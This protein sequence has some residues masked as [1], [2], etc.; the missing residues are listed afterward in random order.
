MGAKMK[1]ANMRCFD[2]GLL[3]KYDT[4]KKEH[5]NI[6]MQKTAIIALGPSIIR[7]F[8]KKT[9]DNI[10][11]VLQD[12]SID[13]VN[14]ALRSK[15]LFKKWFIELSL[16]VNKVL[17]SH[18]D[19]DQGSKRWAHATKITSLYLRDLLYR[20]SEKLTEK[21]YKHAEEM[22]YVPLD[23]IV[24]NSLS[25]SCNKCDCRA[26]FPKN[27]S[28][29]KTEGQFF[30]IQDYLHRHASKAGVPAIWYDDVWVTDKTDSKHNV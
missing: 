30:Y 6:V 4:I 15:K 25:K 22:L 9:K 2:N 24:L 7:M 27:M 16:E 18:K 26:K 13:D 10:V 11:K 1:Q 12:I 5:S 20:C 23:K 21:E 3:K 19:M 29:L 28:E 8:K 14:K 17:K